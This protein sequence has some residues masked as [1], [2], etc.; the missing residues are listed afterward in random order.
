MKIFTK[1]KT[2]ALVVT[3]TVCL[4]RV[5][6]ANTENMVIIPKYN[7]D[8]FNQMILGAKFALQNIFNENS[9]PPKLVPKIPERLN[10]QSDQI[11]FVKDSITNNSRSIMISNNAGD[12]INEHTLAASEQGITVVSFDSPLAGG[13]KNAGEDL[14]V[15]PVDFSKTGKE[16][17]RMAYSILGDDGGDF[18]FLYSSPDATNQNAWVEEMR[19]ELKKNDTY[20]NINEIGIFYPQNDDADGYR[21]IALELVAGKEN[22]TYPTLDLI[23]APTSSGSANAARALLDAGKCDIMKVSGLSVPSEVLEACEKGCEPEFILWDNFALGYLTLQATHALSTKKISGVADEVFSAGRLGDFTIESDPSRDSSRVILGD[24]RR[25]NAQNVE[26]FAFL[27]C[28]QGFCGDSDEY[29]ESRFMSKMKKRALA[30][31]PKVTGMISFL[32]SCLIIIHILRS[33]KRRKSTFQTIMVGISLTDCISSFFGFFLSTW[34]MPHDTWLAYGAKG[35]D[36]TCAL[37]GFF[38]QLGL[39]GSSI[40]ISMLVCYYFLKIVSLW[41]EQR[42]KKVGLYFHLFPWIIALSTAIAG[43]KL[44]LYNPRTRGYLCWIEE[45]PPYCTNS[46][47]CERGDNANNF[48]WSCKLF[49]LYELYL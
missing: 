9:E 4:T 24:F 37:Q 38:F 32:S 22:G 20:S 25:Y 45:Y 23:M 15:A 31:L 19:K 18:V 35:S 7:Q 13:K 3:A 12:E 33:K 17:A 1:V 6:S 8:N 26:R 41:D 29:F 5:K 2:V 47:S 39:C 16:M 14:F 40:Y 34:P 42:I 46:L 44:K 43:L 11:K 48:R 27:D 36:T 30:I 28:I 10:S 49:F 21:N